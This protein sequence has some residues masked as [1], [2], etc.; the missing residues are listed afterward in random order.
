MDLELL[1]HAKEYIEKMANG[2]NPIT[3]KSVSNEDTLNNIRVSRCLFYV[4]SILDEVINN[5]GITKK[6][7]KKIDF[8]LSKEKLNNYYIFEDLAISKIVS[9]LN[10]LKENEDMNNLK[11]KEMS[12]WLINIGLLIEVENYGKKTKIPT[13]EGEKLGMYLEHRY[14]PYGEYDV[15]LY[16]KIAQQFIID[17]FDNLLDFINQCK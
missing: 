11:I 10:E 5:G 3:G 13:A 15:V 6:S 7:S 1:K 9:K 16:N 12:N 8:Y 2:I 17:N 14:G 4:S